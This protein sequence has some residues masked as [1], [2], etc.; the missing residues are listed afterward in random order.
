MD[1]A[2]APLTRASG[3]PSC[4]AS[5][6]LSE[7]WPSRSCRSTRPRV[8]QKRHLRRADLV[9]GSHSGSSS[10]PLE[11][12]TQDL[13]AKAQGMRAWVYPF[14]LDGMWSISRSALPL[15]V[16][17]RAYPASPHLKLDRGRK[18]RSRPEAATKPCASKRVGRT[19]E[20]RASC[21]RQRRTRSP[22]RPLRRTDRP[23]RQRLGP[24]A[25]IVSPRNE[26]H[27]PRRAV[28]KIAPLSP[29]VWS[30]GRIARAT[31][32][33]VM[34]R[35][36]KQPTSWRSSPTAPRQ[37]R[38]RG[39][40]HHVHA[41]RRPRAHLAEWWH[42]MPGA[43]KRGRLRLLCVEDTEGRRF[44]LSRLGPLR[45]RRPP[46]PAGSVEGLLA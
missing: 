2:R 28:L 12:L 26:C 21:P 8:P 6:R 30:T 16:A 33:L 32:P 35:E 36:A 13:E 46:H 23:P 20:R 11:P 22:A 18:K 40:L 17:I 19:H 10:P 3:R 5:I 25:C 39:V 1:K 42:L 7:T 29:A 9:E 24:S 37:F 27:I 45:R 14:A 15:Q 38:W 44:W 41:L 34:L 4:F 31:R 43:I